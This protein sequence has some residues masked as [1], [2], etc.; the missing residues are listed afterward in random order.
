[1]EPLGWLVEEQPELDGLL[2][3]TGTLVSGARVCLLEGMSISW[4]CQSHWEVALVTQGGS[5]IPFSVS[6][7]TDCATWGA[8]LHSLGLISMNDNYPVSPFPSTVPSDS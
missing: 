3:P 2:T 8:P 4:G 7:D 6:S 1:M 5:S